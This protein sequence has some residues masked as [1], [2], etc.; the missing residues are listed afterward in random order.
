MLVDLVIELAHEGSCLKIEFT[1]ERTTN[2]IPSGLV[3][4]EMRGAFNL[5]FESQLNLLV[6]CFIGFSAEDEAHRQLALTRVIGREIERQL[7]RVGDQ[8]PVQGIQACTQAASLF[9]LGD[10]LGL[11]QHNGQLAGGDASAPAT[12]ELD[13]DTAYIALALFVDTHNRDHHFLQRGSA[14]YEPAA[15]AFETQAVDRLRDLY[16]QRSFKSQLFRGEGSETGLAAKTAPKDE[17]P[18]AIEHVITFRY[19]AE[20]VALFQRS[21]LVDEAMICADQQVAGIGVGQFLYQPDKLGQCL[22]CRS[23]Y[24]LRG[25]TGIA[26]LIDQ[27]VVDVNH[28]VITQQRP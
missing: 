14:M 10:R 2:R 28:I 12:D 21:V 9:L 23:K 11:I 26:S 7:M 20:K 16:I 19:V 25:I 24:P 15:R 22:F 1:G 27:V 8:L 6:V 13:V 4:G 3:L 18:V 17:T 5:L